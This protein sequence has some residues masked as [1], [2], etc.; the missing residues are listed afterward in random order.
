MLIRVIYQVYQH[1]K[2]HED[3]FKKKMK[4]KSE[5]SYSAETV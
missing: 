5:Y 1:T 4:E 2:S 3:I